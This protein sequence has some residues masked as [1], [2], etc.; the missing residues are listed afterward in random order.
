M[1]SLAHSFPTQDKLILLEGAH[2][3]RNALPKAETVL[4]PYLLKE[5]YGEA[6]FIVSER[7]IESSTTKECPPLLQQIVQNGGRLVVLTKDADRLSSN[8]L[9]SEIDARFRDRVKVL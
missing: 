1:P 2:S 4:P 6:V 8:P 9:F 5:G 3:A 7:H